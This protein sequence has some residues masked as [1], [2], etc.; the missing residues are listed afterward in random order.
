MDSQSATEYAC[1]VFLFST[2]IFHDYAHLA[3]RSSFGRKHTRYLWRVSTAPWRFLDI[4]HDYFLPTSAACKRPSLI[5]C[6]PLWEKQIEKEKLGEWEWSR[7]LIICRCYTQLYALDVRTE[8]S[9][10]SLILCISVEKN[11]KRIKWFDILIN[12]CWETEKI[13]SFDTDVYTKQNCLFA[14]T[15]TQKLSF[16]LVAWLVLKY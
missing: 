8:Q 9:L 6:D 15:I 5:F 1:P 14:A 2:R 3:S 10:F 16:F 13:K 4:H 11:E 12:A 7:A